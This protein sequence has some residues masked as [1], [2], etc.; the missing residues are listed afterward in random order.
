MRME[1]AATEERSVG[2]LY[3]LTTR[4]LR[5]TWR[6]AEK[7]EVKPTKGRDTGRALAELELRAV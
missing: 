6:G 5:G 2:Y 1:T 4:G 7:N 3:T